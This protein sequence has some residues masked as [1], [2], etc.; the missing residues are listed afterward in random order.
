MKKVLIIEDDRDLSETLSLFL[1]NNKFIVYTACDG[2][3]GVQEAMR[4]FPDIIICDISMPNLDGYGVYETIKHIN[5]T[6]FI[7]FIFLTAKADNQEIRK[8][9]NLGAD[10]YI[11]K[12]FKNNDLLDAVNVRLKKAESLSIMNDKKL[13]TV[14]D[15][16]INGIFICQNKKIIYANNKLADILGYQ[17]AELTELYIEDFINRIIEQKDRGKVLNYFQKA[18]GKD[19]TF[20]VAKIKAVNKTKNL[21]FLEFF[22]KS[23]SFNDKDTLI[24]YIIDIT[25][26]TDE[27][28]DVAASVK[29][30]SSGMVSCREKEVLIFIC[31]GLVNKEIADKL[32]ISKRTV[33]RHRDNLMKKTNSRNTA[34]L[35]MNAIKFGLV[36]L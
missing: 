26:L 4:L 31:Q 25:G 21:I 16:P 3:Q 33:D 7:P 11:T 19:V 23:F 1:R 28:E 6:S 27:E 14:L 29:S 8:G 15:N 13:L 30:V 10:D 12:P 2:I 9:M 34:E 5:S 22:I 18:T 20:D 35:M 32:N 36:E 24:G 17:P